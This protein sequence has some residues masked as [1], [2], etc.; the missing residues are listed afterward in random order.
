MWCC[1]EGNQFY[2]LVKL[3][4]IIY[5]HSATSVIINQNMSEHGRSSV[6]FL[7]SSFVLAFSVSISQN[8][9]T[10]AC[11]DSFMMM[12]MCY[13]SLVIPILWKSI[14]A[15][16]TH[17]HTHTQKNIYI[18][19]LYIYTQCLTKVFIPLHLFDVSCCSPML[20]NLHP[21]HQ[22]ENAKTELSQLRKFIKKKK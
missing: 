5:A 15:T 7:I 16:H 8:P 12:I 20:I 6:T 9:H 10:L 18:F 4:K 22:N 14:S 11:W 3:I 2:P 13:A 21:I 1:R 19:F 17:T